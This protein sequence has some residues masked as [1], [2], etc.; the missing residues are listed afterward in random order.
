MRA[1]PVSAPRLVLDT[2]V[3][4]DLFVFRDPACDRLMDAL[5]EGTVAAVVD[6]PCR[7]EWLAVLEYPAFGL[8]DTAR[9]DAVA[10]FDRWVALLPASALVPPPAVK[11]PR[12]ADPDDQKF[13]ELALGAG[14]QCLLSKDKALLQLARRTAREGWFR[15]LCPSAW[16]PAPAVSVRF[17]TG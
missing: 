16:E 3:A 6:E 7:E 17:T 15:I 13:L 9:G 1:M 4:L 10:A 5:R 8:T 11:L 12:C 14:A 2:N